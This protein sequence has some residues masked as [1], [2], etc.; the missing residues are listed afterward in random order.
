M[1]ATMNRKQQATLDRIIEFASYGSHEVKELDVFDY[2]FGK[3]VHVTLEMGMPN[4]EGTL[5]EA[6]CRDCF[7]FN[8]GERGGIFFFNSERDYAREYIKYW[9]IQ[10]TNIYRR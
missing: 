2:D 1:A 9:D 6:L 5:A 8:I 7:S 3:D 4:D 10:K